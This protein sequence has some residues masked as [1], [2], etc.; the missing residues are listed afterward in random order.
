M[1]LIFVRF[2]TTLTFILFVWSVSYLVY[3]RFIQPAIVAPDDY[4]MADTVSPQQRINLISVLFNSIQ[5]NSIQFNSI[6][7]NSTHSLALFSF[8]LL[9]NRSQKL[10][11]TSLSIDLLRERVKK[12][13]KWML[14]SK[15]GMKSFGNSSILLRMF[16]TPQNTFKYSHISFL[17]FSLF[18]LFTLNTHT[19]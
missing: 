4:E 17:L 14:T 13:R 9:I 11:A 7:F 1:S 3:H 18:F 10:W 12:L 16:P 5:F 15:S 8:F 2:V 19:Y 6:Q